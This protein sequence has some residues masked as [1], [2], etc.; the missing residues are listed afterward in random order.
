MG[1]LSP[2]RVTRVPANLAPR[3]LT[4]NIK[5][6]K[7]RPILTPS[8]GARDRQ[9]ERAYHSQFEK[10]N[11]FSKNAIFQKTQN[12]IRVGQFWSLPGTPSF[13]CPYAA[14]NTNNENQQITKKHV[15]FCLRKSYMWVRPF[16]ALWGGLLA[17]A[18]MRALVVIKT[19]KDFKKNLR[20][21]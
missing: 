12:Y 2:F 20:F 16:F 3:A 18:I 9:R 1:L 7:G 8:R 10:I 19:F 6:Y 5:I 4:K 14:I 13:G 21:V 17:G 11:D 15:I